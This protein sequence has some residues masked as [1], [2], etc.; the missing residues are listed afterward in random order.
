MKRLKNIK[1]LMIL[2][3]FLTLAAVSFFCPQY[4]ENVARAFLLLLGAGL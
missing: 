3:A 4:A 1:K 2:G